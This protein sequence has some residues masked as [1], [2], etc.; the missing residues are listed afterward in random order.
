MRTGTGKV[1]PSYNHIF[2]DAAVQVIM[3]HIEAIPDHDIGII[4]TTPGVAHNAQAPHTGVI[5]IA[6]TATHHIDPTKD[7]LHTEAPH[8]TTP[9]TK[10]THDHIHPINPQDDIHIGHS[11]TPADHEANHMTRGT[12]E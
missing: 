1:V 5:A 10:V 8:H 4:T 12:P 3:I 9:E 2:T 6:P 7:H 11:H